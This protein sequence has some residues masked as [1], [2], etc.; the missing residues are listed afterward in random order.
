MPIYYESCMA[1]IELPEEGRRL[2]REL[3]EE[4][5]EDDAGQLDE[6]RG[7]CARLETLIDS[8]KRLAYKLFFDYDS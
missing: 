8:E 5:E 6:A 4:L 2:V 3:D 7:R 1:K